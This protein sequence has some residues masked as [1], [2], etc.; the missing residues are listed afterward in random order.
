MRYNIE[1]LEFLIKG[2]NDVSFHG[3]NQIPTPNIDA[4]AYNGVILQRHYVLPICTPSRTAFLT[5]R[6]PIRTGIGTPGYLAISKQMIRLKIL[7]M[8][9]SFS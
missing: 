5:G 2:W 3:A 7:L 6:Y 8:Y 1:F 4:L 9:H